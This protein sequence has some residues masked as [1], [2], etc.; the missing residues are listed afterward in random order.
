MTDSMRWLLV[1]IWSGNANLN[2]IVYN[3]CINNISVNIV[4]ISFIGIGSHSTWRRAPTCC[5]S[6]SNFITWSWIKYVY[7]LPWAV[8]KWHTIVV[9]HTVCIQ[10]CKSKY[11]HNSYWYGGQYQDIQTAHWSVPWPKDSLSIL[12]LH[13][14][15]V[16]I[17]YC[18]EDQKFVIMI[19]EGFPSLN[20]FY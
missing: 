5:M 4:A 19:I 7:I 9:I 20:I 17:V 6:L 13:S 16:T 8:I 11:S 1:Y 15:S 3:T 18:I 10:T 14:I 2:Y 12:I